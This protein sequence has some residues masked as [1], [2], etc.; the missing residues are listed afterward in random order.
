[1]RTQL[2]SYC[3]QFDLTV[4]PVLEDLTK[5]IGALDA[6]ADGSLAHSL[7]APLCGLQHDLQAR[8]P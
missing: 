5:A 4:R 7:R 2:G 6:A 8:S 3:Q 1:M